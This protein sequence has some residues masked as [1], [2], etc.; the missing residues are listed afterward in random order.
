VQERSP[1]QAIEP[2]GRHGLPGPPQPRHGSNVV[3]PMRSCRA[4]DCGRAHGAGG[5]GSA[6]DARA[7]RSAPSAVGV[8]SAPT[9]VDSGWVE[10]AT[11]PEGGQYD[12]RLRQHSDYGSST[13]QG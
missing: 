2:K 11:A 4:R 9:Y 6:A 5:E 10:A 7:D 12:N 13:G 8:G 3:W 1:A